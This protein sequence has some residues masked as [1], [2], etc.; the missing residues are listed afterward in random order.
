MPVNDSSD[1]SDGNVAMRSRIDQHTN[2]LGGMV[3]FGRVVRAGP[4]D[5]EAPGDI[6]RILV[7][8]GGDTPGSHTRNWMPWLNARAGYDGEW[9]VPD[10]DEQVLVVAPTGNLVLGVVIGSIYRGA[11]TF[12]SGAEGIEH[13]VPYPTPLSE[14]GT[15]DNDLHTRVYKDGTSISYDRQ[16]HRLEVVVKSDAEAE[17]S[18]SI[19]CVAD[20]FVRLAVGNSKITIEKKDGQ[21]SI[22]IEGKVTIVGTL[23][24]TD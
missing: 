6:P 1:Q 12:A 18:V 19:S 13:K 22:V 17:P 24:V 15:Q 4:E 20:E 23:D 3:M 5:A 7:Q 21:E 14:L 16:K 10:I 9:W 8:V 11:L 2:M